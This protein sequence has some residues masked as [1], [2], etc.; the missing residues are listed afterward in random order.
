MNRVIT[1]LAILVA[2]SMLA[3]CGEP[4]RTS[5]SGQELLTWAAEAPA[6]SCDVLS[7]RRSDMTR[8]MNGRMVVNGKT[9]YAGSVDGGKMMTVMLTSYKIQNRN[10]M[11]RCATP[12]EVA[13]YQQTCAM[14]PTAC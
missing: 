3:S 1:S 6:T 14:L 2:T 13:A 11:K 10:Y 5:I 9:V 12:K 7:Q 4:Q 8:L